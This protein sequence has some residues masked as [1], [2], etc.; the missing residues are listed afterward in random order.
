MIQI[1]SRECT[2]IA[3]LYFLQKMEVLIVMVR[4]VVAVVLFQITLSHRNALTILNLCSYSSWTRLSP[5]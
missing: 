5:R 4:R 1:K 2:V 3:I